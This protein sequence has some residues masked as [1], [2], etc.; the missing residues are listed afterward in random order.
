[1]KKYC[2][3]IMIVIAGVKS[4][5]A[6]PLN[7][8]T[9]NPDSIIY[10]NGKQIG[11]ESVYNYDINPGTH[12]LKIMDKDTISFS[13]II[14]VKN[15]KVTTVDMLKFINTTELEKR[16]FS[17]IKLVKKRLRYL[18]GN[19]GVGV[20]AGLISGLSINTIMNGFRFNI[21]GWKT[22]ENNHGM[23]EVQLS[24]LIKDKV[25]IMD[26]LISLYG[27][28]GSGSKKSSDG[29]DKQ[30][31]A[32]TLGID[33]QVGAGYLNFDIQYAFF[34]SNSQSNSK[35]GLIAKFGYHYYF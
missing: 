28:L 30:F 3:L 8:I 25:S 6:E 33:R 14:D 7:V 10:I 1:M 32:F 20:Q 15:D 27:G 17:T 23:L 12:H 34:Q 2:L 11:V 19:V 26:T 35:E 22:P 29:T 13:K 18:R 4:I 31:W 24:H 5:S 9:G 16:N 21:V